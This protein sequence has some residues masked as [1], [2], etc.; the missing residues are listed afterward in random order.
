[1]SAWGGHAV[2]EPSYEVRRA[3]TPLLEHPATTAIVTDFDGTLSPIVDD[4]AQARPLD[5][6]A[7]IIETLTRRFGMVA[8]VSGRPV[9]FLMEHLAPVAPASLPE[10][11]ALA[12]AEP[13]HSTR[14]VGLYGLEWSQPG[15][16]VISEPEAEAWRPAVDQAAGRLR[17]SAPKLAVVEAKGLAVTV[18]WRRRPEAASWAASA[19]EA[20]VA[21]TG[22]RAHPGRMSIELRPPLDIDKGTALRRLVAGSS[23]ACYFGDDLGDLPAFAVL[24]D[25]ASAGGM[26]TVSVA[27]VD[28]ESAED[29]AAAADVVV[30][31][32]FEALKALGWLAEEAR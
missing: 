5:G 6:A 15:G 22:L 4:P 2:S 14:F 27:V 21:R 29:V 7:R 12:V 3:L 28:S 1:V 30:P 26:T 24:A 20:E 9:S 17:T 11:A 19:V 31:G 8:V 25:L 18:H 16:V 13:A 32:P 23:A 10:A